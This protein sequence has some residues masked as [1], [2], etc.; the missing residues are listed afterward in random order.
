MLVLL[1]VACEVAF[2][3]LLGAGLVA[4]S[5]FAIGLFGNIPALIIL[6]LLAGVGTALW[7][8]S[9]CAGGMTSVM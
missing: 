5:T 3:V 1:I 6:R 4:I 7:G 8:L 2:W 9:R